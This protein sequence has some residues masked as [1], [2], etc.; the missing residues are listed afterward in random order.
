MEEKKKLLEL[1]EHLGDNLTVPEMLKLI[2]FLNDLLWIKGGTD[3]VAKT[4]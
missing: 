2:T 1:A 4:A 3:K